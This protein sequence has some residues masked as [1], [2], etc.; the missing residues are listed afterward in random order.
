MKKSVLLM[1]LSLTLLTLVSQ[2]EETLSPAKETVSKNQ[3]GTEK[4][5]VYLDEDSPFYAPENKI[6]LSLINQSVKKFNA[7][8]KEGFL[9]MFNDPEFYEPVYDHLVMEKDAKIISVMN[10]RF[11]KEND[12]VTVTVDKKCSIDYE[13]GGTEYSF[14]EFGNEWKLIFID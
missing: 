9:D 10:P 2:R 1:V 14:M 11:R 12:L 6:F 3:W 13:C 4:V 5:V 8:D 7:R